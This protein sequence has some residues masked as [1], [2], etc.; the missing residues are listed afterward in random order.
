LLGL[1]RQKLASSAETPLDYA[2][3]ADGGHS[4]P[5]A[6]DGG[7][8][9]KPLPS[10]PEGEHRTGA[11]SRAEADRIQDQYIDA[12]FAAL[13]ANDASCNEHTNY[14]PLCSDIIRPWV[15]CVDDDSDF[16]DSLKLRLQQHG[17]EVLQAFA[18]MAGYRTAFTSP[19]QAIILDQTMPDGN[20]EYVLRR[21]KENPVTQDIPVI[22]LT[23]T[24][25]RMLER[26]MYNLGAVRFLTKPVAWDDL[27]AELRQHIRLTPQPSLT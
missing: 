8:T 14:D 20:G 3:R 16:A 25:D 19:A 2:R 27:W 9:R 23:G 18:G 15:L 26:K 17:V 5:G 11:E 24:K 10:R 12:I 22:V 6:S 13:G 7:L 1:D 4:S 21:L